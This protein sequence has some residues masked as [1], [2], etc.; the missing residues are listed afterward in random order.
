MQSKG[1]EPG[2]VTR[3]AAFTL[4]GIITYVAAISVVGNAVVL[5]V[6]MLQT[7]LELRL[8]K[9]HWSQRLMKMTK[10]SAV[11]LPSCHLVLACS[12]KER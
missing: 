11:A 1:L 4:S 2:T 3:I 9:R 8:Q 5:L 12:N 6:C 10:A 7:S